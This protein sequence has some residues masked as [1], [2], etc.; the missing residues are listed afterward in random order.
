MVFS[1]TI[2]LF[3]FLPLVLL[4]YFIAPKV[5]R[6]T[7]LLLASLFFYTWGER[8]YAVVLIGSIIGNYVAGMLLA[9]TRSKWLLAAAIAGNM[10]LLIGFK[11]ANFLQDNLNLLLCWMDLPPTTMFQS[12]VHLPIGVSF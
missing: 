11:Y 6:N 3:G 5:A 2:F 4:L 10:L 9:K 1:S 8:Q 12:Q 7:V